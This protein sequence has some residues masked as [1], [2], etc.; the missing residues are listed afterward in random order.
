MDR[1]DPILEA[2]LSEALGGHTPP[3]VTAR[4]LQAWAAKGHDPAQ[5]DPRLLQALQGAPIPPPINEP[6]W[7]LPTAPPVQHVVPNGVYANGHFSEPPMVAPPAVEV[8]AP[9]VSVKPRRDMHRTSASWLNAV[10]AASALA[11]VSVAGYL[12]YQANEQRPSI[13]EQGPDKSAPPAPSPS[14]RPSQA[15]QDPQRAAPKT[16]TQ[17]PVFGRT[18]NEAVAIALPPSKWQDV[19]PT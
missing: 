6:A 19:K 13:A 4:V 9:V 11:V 10:V 12:V 1:E 7:M 3:D 18:D 16:N 15:D 2:L 14:P 17:D 8:A 5:L